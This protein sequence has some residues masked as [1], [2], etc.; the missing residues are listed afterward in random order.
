MHASSLRSITKQQQLCPCC[1]TKQTNKVHRSCAGDGKCARC[2]HRRCWPQH[3]A[4]LSGRTRGMMS[5]ADQ[6]AHSLYAASPK[7]GTSHAVRGSWQPQNS[8]AC[9]PSAPQGSA[10]SD[11]SPDGTPLHSSSRHPPSLCPRPSTHYSVAPSA[12]RAMSSSRPFCTFCIRT[13]PLR[14]IALRASV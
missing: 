12:S 1:T 7:Q 6:V 4:P 10:G 13:V 5:A 2:T 11:P 9:T 3:H 14:L 8:T